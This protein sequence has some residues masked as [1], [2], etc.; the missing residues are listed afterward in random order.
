M[1]FS[2]VNPTG[3]TLVLLGSGGAADFTQFANVTFA[4]SGVDNISA[5]TPPTLLNTTV[6]PDAGGGGLNL[7]D[8]AGFNS[9]IISG[10][11]TWQL[12]VNNSSLTDNVTFDPVTLNVSAVPFEFDG[13]A[14]MA[15]V[16]GA[17]VLNRWYKKRKSSG[18]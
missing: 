10:N 16:G 17:F 3:K 7:A 5:L 6:L 4:D 11:Q 12:I 8:F 15:I 14:G 2:L 9:D 1:S 18:E 13:S